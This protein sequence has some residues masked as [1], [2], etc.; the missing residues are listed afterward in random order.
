MVNIYEG[1]PLKRTPGM[2]HTSYTSDIKIFSCF[3]SS[4]LLGS[5]GQRSLYAF[6]LNFFFFQPICL[7][8]SE[9]NRGP[10]ASSSALHE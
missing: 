8:Y 6:N 5:I 9:G 2:T 3:S 1:G 4:N 10:I 7:R